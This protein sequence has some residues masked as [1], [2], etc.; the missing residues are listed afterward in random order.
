METKNHSFLSK[1]FVLIKQNWLQLIPWIITS[2]ILIITIILL[3]VWQTS[4]VEHQVIG[5][6][7]VLTDLAIMQQNIVSGFA[8]SFVFAITTAI[9]TTV[10]IAYKKK[11]PKTRG[12]K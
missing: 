8:L 4:L 2:I 3:V 5:N 1:M 6:N 11:H 9:F 12:T 7:K 10:I